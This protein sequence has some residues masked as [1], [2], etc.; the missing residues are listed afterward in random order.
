MS[1]SEESVNGLEEDVQF[2]CRKCPDMTFTA[3]EKDSHRNFHRIEKE[4]ERERQKKSKP[5]PK[6]R[7]RP[8][9]GR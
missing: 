6:S 5:G 3:A 7:T 9:R 4:K 8:S 2:K 1:D